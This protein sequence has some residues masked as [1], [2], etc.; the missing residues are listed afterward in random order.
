MLGVKGCPSAGLWEV[1]ENFMIPNILVY[2]CKRGTVEQQPA[3]VAGARETQGKYQNGLSSKKRPNTSP[4][5]KTRINPLVAEP[6]APHHG[7]KHLS[8]NNYSKA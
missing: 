6:R 4:G 7:L 5:S 8:L 1:V 2:L 3:P